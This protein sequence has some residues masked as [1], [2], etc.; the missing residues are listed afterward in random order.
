MHV[1]RFGVLF[2]AVTVATA[3]VVIAPTTAA[4]SQDQQYARRTGSVGG[5]PEASGEATASTR[6]RS[7][8]LTS[9]I[10]IRMKM[11]SLSFPRFADQTVAVRVTAQAT[12]VAVN[13]DLVIIRRGGL[14]IGIMNMRVNAN[15]DTKLTESTARAALDKINRVL[16]S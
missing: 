3:L 2:R 1:P 9:G 8:P 10:T 13:M 16:G 7:G 11:S 15:T 14:V 4:C 5:G 6:P 12:G